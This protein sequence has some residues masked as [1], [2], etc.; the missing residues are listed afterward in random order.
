MNRSIY[1]GGRV[2]HVDD[3]RGDRGGWYFEV[4]D[5]DPRGPFATRRLA[6]VALAESL[7]RMPDRPR[8]QDSKETEGDE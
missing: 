5:A 7:S 1:R 2:F 3:P 4:R 6:E 8:S